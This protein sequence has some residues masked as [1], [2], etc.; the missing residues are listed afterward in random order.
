LE[1][2]GIRGQLYGDGFDELTALAYLDLQWCSGMTALPDE[3]GDLIGLQ[4]L[5]LMRCAGLTQLPARIGDLV[6]LTYLDLSGCAG[7]LDLPDEI[8]NLTKLTFI[9][10]WECQL[11]TRIPSTFMQ[12]QALTS[13][14]LADCTALVDLPD[15]SQ[16]RPALMIPVNQFT[17]EVVHAWVEANCVVEPPLALQQFNNPVEEH[18]SFDNALDDAGLKTA[19][20][21]SFALPTTKA[22][23][24][25]NASGGIRSIPTRA[26]IGSAGDKNALLLG[27]A[28]D[29]KL[30]SSRGSHANIPET[31]ITSVTMPSATIGSK[32]SA[33][34]DPL[35]L[36]LFNLSQ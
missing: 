7:L 34:A 6:N 1:G 12:L 30:S 32:Q 20:P 11:I 27:V 26:M 3:L 4:S 35:K 33:G 18:A 14:G 23:G 13:L 19:E 24:S 21:L 16:L 5:E 22:S 10:L 36:G 25:S 15:L 31:S 9:D 8:G 29:V 2:F 17:S 28:T